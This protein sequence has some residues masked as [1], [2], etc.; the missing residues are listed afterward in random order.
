VTI[1]I[2]LN[3]D[4]SIIELA[5]AH[6]LVCI[7]PPIE[8]QWWH[9]FVHRHHKHCFAIKREPNGLWT[10]FEPWWTRVLLAS[11][12]TPQAAQYLTWATHGD[13]FLV[14]AEIPGKSS[15]LRGMMTCGA[16]IAH[17]LGRTDMVWTPHQLYK[18]L[19]V[20][21]NVESVPKNTLQAII[22]G[23]SSLSVA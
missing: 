15:Q 12:T 20:D 11:I 17:M 5:P 13:V 23:S 16:L 6:W 8:I 1:G 19:V 4:G 2:K 21:P 9:R 10:L 14:K 18:R 3:P 22:Q 7:V